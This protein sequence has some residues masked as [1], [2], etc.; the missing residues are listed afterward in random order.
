LVI[1]V[2]FCNGL[3]GET[4]GV[5]G[6]VKWIPAS[7]WELNL[8][9]NLLGMNLNPKTSSLDT[10]TSNTKNNTPSF[11]W[12]LRSYLDLPHNLELGTTVYHV[13][14]IGNLR[15]PAYVRWDVRFGW[16]PKDNIEISVGVLNINDSNHPEFTEGKIALRSNSEVPRRVYGKL[17]WNFN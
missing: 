13:G 9:F 16:K 1:P 6:A 8:G 17:I 7:W 10:T 12:H 11:Q 3:E 14:H 5:E 4:F 2:K 15:V